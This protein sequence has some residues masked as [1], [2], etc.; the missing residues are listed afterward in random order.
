VQVGL[1]GRLKSNRVSIYLDQQAY[2]TVGNSQF[3]AHDKQMNPIT[4]H[5]LQHTPLVAYEIPQLLR[6]ILNVLL[7]RHPILFPIP[8]VQLDAK[9][10]ERIR[11][12]S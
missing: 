8:H 10:D 9:K 11:L 3:L 12:T 4:S 6:Q 5:H 2:R 1:K 7:H